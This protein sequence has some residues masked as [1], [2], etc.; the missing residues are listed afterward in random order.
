[1]GN[2]MRRLLLSCLLL[3]ALPAAALAHVERTSYW[4]DPAPDTSVR[5]AAGGAVPTPR[6]L[7]SALDDSARGTTRVV[8]KGNSLRL[9]RADIVRARKQG[10]ELRPTAP[11]TKLTTDQAATLLDINTRLFDRCRYHDIQPAVT[12]TRNND[13]VVVMPGLYTEEPSRK[14]P[15]F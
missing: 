12:A 11:T 7:A 3:L 13:R 2:P 5:P 1:M 10:Y 6:S 4:P 15:S 9:A 8:C 14:V